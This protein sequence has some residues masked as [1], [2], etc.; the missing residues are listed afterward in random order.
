MKKDK[1]SSPPEN[2]LRKRAEAR[3][4]KMES[5]DLPETFQD[6][7]RLLHELQVHQIELEIQNEELRHARDEI[8]AGLARYSDLYD[9]APVGY[10]TLDRNSAILQANLTGTLLLG[11]DRARLVTRRFDAFVAEESRP[12]FNVF[13]DQVFA[14]ANTQTCEIALLK[15]EQPLHLRLEGLAEATGEACRVIT[16]DISRRKKI[17]AE[18]EKTRK[19]YKELLIYA[20]SI[21]IQMDIKGTIKFIN[22]Y[23][24]KFF[25]YDLD[26]ILDKN[27][28][29]LMPQ[30]DSS[31]RNM[32]DMAAHIRNNPDD[33]QEYMTESILKTGERVW[34]SWRSKTLKD[35]NGNV[36]GNLVVGTDIT[37]QKRLT[38]ALQSSHDELEQRVAERT[39]ELQKAFSELQLLKDRLEAENIY[40]QEELK[41]RHQSRDIIGQS[42]ALAH[43]LFRSEQVAPLNTTVLIL[44]ETGTGKELIAATIHN[45]SPRKKRPMITVNC[46]ALPNN[47]IESE[48]FGREKGAFTGADTRRVGRFEVADGST[49]CLDEIGEMPIEMQAKLLR[50]IQ[51]QEFERLGSSHTMKVDVRIIATTNRNL[52]EEVKKGRFREDLFYRLNV[53]P[54]TVPPLRQRSKDIPL[55]VQAFVQQYAMKLGKRIT[56][57]SKETMKVLEKYQWPGNV[58]ELQNIL[59]RAVILCHG[60][61]FMLSEKLEASS[62]TLA[63]TV[64][65]L[66]ETE[67]NQIL[68]TLSEN[69]WR[70]EGKGGAAEVLGINPST[71]RARMHKLGIARPQA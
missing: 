71:L 42:D 45:M 26:G 50:V 4:K 49:I 16:I 38:A 46:G 60:P 31:G 17:E 53:F 62:P 22:E 64:Q 43:V 58:R 11:T 63:S 36:I 25:G 3:L 24:Q 37:E 39:E 35:E 10:F 15:E 44:G 32:E 65:T 30:T 57:I 18:L 52:E 48:L 51:H 2:K 5:H 56:S 6:T 68:K 13:L 66:E 55:L 61:E 23:A 54:I 19:R 12:G 9:F 8:E 20:N 14:D 47:L 21:I 28:N 69:K 7:Q 40:F 41:M 1:G 67:R 70:I 59:E 27:V 34:I 29:I 33:F